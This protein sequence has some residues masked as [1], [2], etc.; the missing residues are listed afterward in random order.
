MD[1]SWVSV[2][3]RTG[4]ILADLPLLDVDKI[5][6]S[7]SRYDS[8]TASLPLAP[9][10]AGWELATREGGAV[11][12]LLGDATPIWG[13]IVTQAPRGSGD[14]VEMS[15]ATVESYFDRR[16]VGDVT[17]TQVGQNAIVAD[18]IARYVATGPRGGLP[19]RAVQVGGAGTLRDRTY[20]DASDK[21]VYSCL[22]EL[23]A[24]DGG[25]EWTVEW[26]WQ[27][28][29]ERI[30]PVLYV[31]ARIGAAVNAG[32]APVSTF[33]LPGCVIEATVFRDYSAGKGANVVVAVSSAVADVRPQS[34]A[35][36]A[37]DDGRPTY[38]HRWTPSTSITEVSTLTAHARSALATLAPGAV[39]VTLSANAGTAPR[40]GIDWVLG[41]DVGYALGGLETDPR[42][43]MVDVYDDLWSDIWSDTWGGTFLRRE[44]A[45]VNPDGRDSVPAFPGGIAGAARAIGW[46]LTLGATPIVTPILATQ[47]A[48]A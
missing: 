26:E 19:I 1:Y 9:P 22:T 33:D 42:T 21:T 7:I 43:H 44:K 14:T 25:P 5:K 47:G 37:A 41:D 23:A 48:S 13:G 31:G 20:T 40:L 11:M 16:Y 39:A 8:A 35:Q 4:V 2:D 30:T 36:V 18:L 24:V 38:E 6:R 3:A 29:P 10:P 34:P 17:Y 46:E 12:V 45:L 32:L 27:H 28:D 15:L